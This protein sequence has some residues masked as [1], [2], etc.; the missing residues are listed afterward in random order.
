M[1]RGYLAGRSPMPNPNSYSLP[2]LTQQSPALAA[3]VSVR[4]PISKVKPAN[5]KHPKI[6]YPT[7]GDE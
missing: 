1:N 5:G 4:S 2:T 6:S 3:R 7:C